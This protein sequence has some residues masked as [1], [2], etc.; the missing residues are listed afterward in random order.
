MDVN[1]QEEN[2]VVTVEWEEEVKVY[3]LVCSECLLINEPGINVCVH[4]D[5]ELT[6]QI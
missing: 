4:C 5:G 6:P 1:L 3:P 2:E